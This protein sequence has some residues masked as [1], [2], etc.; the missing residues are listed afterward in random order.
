MAKFLYE[1]NSRNNDLSK[2]F[3]ENKRKKYYTVNNMTMVDG[4]GKDHG[5][6]NLVDNSSRHNNDKIKH[7]TEYED[8]GIRNDSR[9]K[10][11]NERKNILEKEMQKIDLDM[12]SY[13]N[14]PTNRVTHLNP[15]QN[16]EKT[17]MT[18]T[19][20][21]VTKDC[22]TQ[23]YQNPSTTDNL[24]INNDNKIK[25]KIANDQSENGLYIASFYKTRTNPRTVKKPCLLNIERLETNEKKCQ[26]IAEQA[27][28]RWSREILSIKSEQ[29]E[30]FESIHRYNNIPK[31]NHAQSKQP[32]KTNRVKKSHS[33]Y[34]TQ[35]PNF[36][37]KL[38][39]YPDSDLS[40]SEANG[41][42]DDDDE[43]STE[44]YDSH[45]GFSPSMME[46]GDSELNGPIKYADGS[47]KT[48]FKRELG[49]EEKI[50]AQHAFLNESTRN[51]C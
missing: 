11:L 32:V 45:F 41:K 3:T 21:R 49:K 39:Y 30:I 51:M 7:I 27:T 12:S 10:Y 6:C 28:P 14:V 4:R 35:T 9:K 15:K 46:S 16:I 18:E 5:N 19:A 13:S 40:S 2:Q 22:G 8:I 42:V 20:D 50:V 26:N 38:R 33:L 1:K 24:K 44:R 17:S 48:D 36:G 23:I 25:L 31:R 37:G 47:E 34:A 29:P 43:V